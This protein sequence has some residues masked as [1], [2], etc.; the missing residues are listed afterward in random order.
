M[1]TI[2]TRLDLLTVHVGL[3]LQQQRVVTYMSCVETFLIEIKIKSSDQSSFL[4]ADQDIKVT[5]E[6]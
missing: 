6:L 5:S 4:S 2:S 1:T 3:L